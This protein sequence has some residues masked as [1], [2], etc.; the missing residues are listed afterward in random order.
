MKTQIRLN[1][2]VPHGVSGPDAGAIELIYEA[3][4]I[5]YKQSA[6][7]YISINQIGN[8]LDEVMIKE[9]KNMHLNIRYP[10]PA[11]FNLKT[12]VYTKTFFDN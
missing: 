9:G 3:L 11:D 1:S 4:M 5:E 12:D 7:R 6:Y 2:V 10:S 8:D